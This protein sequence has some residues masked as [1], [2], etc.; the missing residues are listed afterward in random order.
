MNQVSAQ[1]SALFSGLSVLVDISADVCPQAECV[2]AA[3]SVSCRDIR[4]TAGRGAD[5]RSLWSRGQRAAV[6]GLPASSGHT[7]PQSED[8]RASEGRRDAERDVLLQGDDMK[9]CLVLVLLLW[10]G[11]LHLGEWTG[12]EP[13]ALL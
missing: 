6:S 13:G 4:V 10:S 9:L 5:S 7:G 2:S 8:S 1:S 12:S 11:T 3:Q